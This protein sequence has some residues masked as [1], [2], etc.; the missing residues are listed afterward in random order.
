MDKTTETNTRGTCCADCCFL[1]TLPGFK[2]MGLC[3]HLSAAAFNTV[4]ELAM[5][6]CPEFKEVPSVS[7]AEGP[8]LCTI[9]SMSRDS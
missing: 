2:S 1:L 4:V 5:Q 7:R 8:M 9:S 6:G 3:R